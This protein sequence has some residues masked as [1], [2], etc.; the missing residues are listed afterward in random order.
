MQWYFR[1]DPIREVGHDL[2]LPAQSSDVPLH[3]SELDRLRI[4]LNARHLGLREAGAVSELSLSNAA[5]SGIPARLAT[6]FSKVGST[7]DHFAVETLRQFEQST[8]LS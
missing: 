5:V 4:V 2:D 6:F 3:C 7:G 8:T 1:V